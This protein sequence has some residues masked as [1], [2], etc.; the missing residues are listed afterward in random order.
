MDC[1]LEQVMLMQVLA[2]SDTPPYHPLA[3]VGLCSPSLASLEVKSTPPARA[4]VFSSFFLLT[5]QPRI[6]L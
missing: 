2:K 3:S 4:R 1:V 6:S 5:L